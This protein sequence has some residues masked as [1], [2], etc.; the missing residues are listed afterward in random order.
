MD[1]LTK[2]LNIVKQAVMLGAE[3]FA[4]LELTA[5][6]NSCLSLI[7]STGVK[8]EDLNQPEVESLVLI[9]VKT[10]YG[11]NSDGT[12]KELPQSFYLLLKQFSLKRGQ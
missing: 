5:L 9:Y 2:L 4:D 1:L 10:F 11:F 3:T 12:V 7:T 6:I 8:E